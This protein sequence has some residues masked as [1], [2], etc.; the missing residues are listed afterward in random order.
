MGILSMKPN[1]FNCKIN[2]VAQFRHTQTVCMRCV[3]S[4]EELSVAVFVA[5]VMAVLGL[6][7]FC[8]E[9]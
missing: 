1:Y 8:V 4:M 5:E 6:Y 9:E 3:C 2:T 7:R